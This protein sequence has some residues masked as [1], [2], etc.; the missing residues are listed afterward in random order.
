MAKETDHA[1]LRA[2]AGAIAG[3][4]NL[5][6]IRLTKSNVRLNRVQAPTAQLN[7]DVEMSPSAS[8]SLD[9]DDEG[10]LLVNADFNVRIMDASDEADPI[11]E[12]ECTFVAAFE[13][14][15]DSEPSGDELGA[16]AETTGLSA[17]YPYAREYISDATRRM[18]LPAL[19][20]DLL[21]P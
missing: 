16:F 11:A 21:K 6:D 19:V 15:L 20:L 10:L 5:F 17:V 18:G 13:S 4:S 9:G 2:R 1:A 12:V 14:H 8:I 3:T 7:V